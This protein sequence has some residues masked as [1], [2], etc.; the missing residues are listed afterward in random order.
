MI[1]PFGTT[2]PARFALAIFAGLLMLGS[3]AVAAGE[4]APGSVDDLFGLEPETAPAQPEAPA[5]AEVAPEGIP[6]GLPGDVDSLFGLEP[7]AA[8]AA[9]ATAAGPEIF[10]FVQSELAYNYASP[11][12]WQKFKNTLE[13]GSRGSWGGG[14]RWYASARVTLDPVFAFEDFYPEQV[15]DNR[16]WEGMIREFYVDIPRG[17]WD[18]RLGRQHVI[19]GEMAA[20]FFADV[21]S[22]RDL[23]EFVL[24]DF[25]MLRIPQWA[26]RAEYFKGNFHAEALYIPYMTYDEIGAPGDDYFPFVP[27]P[28]PGFQTLVRDDRRPGDELSNSGYG[29]RANYLKNGWDGSV[30]YYT[31]MGLTP[32]FGRE[33]RATAPL[34]TLFFR[35]EYT[36]E[37]QVG[38]TVAKDFGRAVFKAEAVY[39]QNRLFETG[40]LTD[41]DGIVK[42]DLVNYV[43]GLDFSFPEDTLLHLEAFQYRFFDHDQGIVFDRVE[44]GF[45]F[46][47]RTRYLHPDVEAEALYVTSVNRTDSMLQAKLTW[48]FAPNW[49]VVGGTDVFFGDS[50][51]LF[52]RFSATDR[53]Y[54]E[55]RRSF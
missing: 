39:V 6:E 11:T 8:P 15:Q 36:R 19:W 26:A 23:R 4:S 35:P 53:V 10:G 17:N 55:I 13:L 48:E 46:L 47:A 9:P 25:D 3:G 49:R 18:F 2:W 7:E 12:H 34:P 24:T 50:P 43:V 5:P 30:F 32:A 44:T 21:V 45:T 22:A 54:T 38:G 29:L 27:P 20:L 31:A 14:A 42:Q 51:Y 1:D 16:Q 28:V 40:T 37:Y 41:V 33:V 52:G